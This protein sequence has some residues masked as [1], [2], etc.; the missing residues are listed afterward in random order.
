MLGGGGATAASRTSSCLVLLLQDLGAVLGDPSGTGQP[1]A[2]TDTSTDRVPHLEI[3]R[4]LWNPSPA[5][6]GCTSESIEPSTEHSL[7]AW[8]LTSPTH[9]TTHPQHIFLTTFA[10]KFIELY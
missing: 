7:L 5:G 3:C 1:A 10:H 9:P 4:D 8:L 2:L 6:M